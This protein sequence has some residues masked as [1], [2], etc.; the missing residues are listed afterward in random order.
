MHP[1]GGGTDRWRTEVVADSIG[2]WTYV[3]EAWSDPLA[4]WYHAVEVKA[5]AGQSADELANDFEL[6]AAAVR[7]DRPKRNQPRP[8]ELAQAVAEDLRR[9]TE[10]DLPLR[11]T[12]AMCSEARALAHDH[13]I[14]ELITRSP[15]YS[16]WVDRV[17][18]PVRRLVRVLPALDRGRTGQRPE[19]PGPPGPARHASPTR[20]GTWTTWPTSASTWSTCRRSTRSGG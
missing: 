9:D 6:G 5:D 19:R 10:V 4:T 12:R 1:L 11:I 13:P 2:N 3:V 14:R 7:A 17:A 16:I 8:S 20:P 18:G 15:R